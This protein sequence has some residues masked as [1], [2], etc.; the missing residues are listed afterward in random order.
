M[1]TTNAL[2]NM[3]IWITRCNL[4]AHCIHRVEGHT[5]NVAQ[6]IVLSQFMRRVVLSHASSNMSA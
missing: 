3:P 6:L 1:S 2:R 5:A 4:R